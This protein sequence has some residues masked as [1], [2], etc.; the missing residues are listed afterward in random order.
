MGATPIVYSFSCEKDPSPGP[1]ELARLPS[2]AVVSSSAAAPGE[3]GLLQP[4]QSI[5]VVSSQA[6][7]SSEAAWKD[8]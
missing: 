5:A 7:D 1:P 3:W 8:W 4:Q 6:I 2:V